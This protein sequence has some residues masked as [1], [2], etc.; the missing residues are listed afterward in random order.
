MDSFVREFRN[1]GSF[2]LRLSALYKIRGVHYT[3][4]SV[5]GYNRGIS[6]RTLGRF[7][8]IREICI[9]F[10]PFFSLGKKI[11]SLTSREI[12]YKMEKMSLK[13]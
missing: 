10:H 2:A 3:K 12:E 5:E 8:I 13:G 1:Y 7:V 4:M 6:P 11:L 9:F